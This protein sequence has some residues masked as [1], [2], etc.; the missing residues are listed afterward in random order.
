MGVAGGVV[1]SQWVHSPLSHILMLYNDHP[2]VERD[3]SLDSHTPFSWPIKPV[4]LG[5]ITVS[6]PGALV[7][8]FIK[9]TATFMQYIDS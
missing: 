6:N 8:M 2:M 5:V 7:G 3:F 1:A 9:F 4:A